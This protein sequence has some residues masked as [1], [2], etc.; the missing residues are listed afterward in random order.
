MQLQTYAKI[1]IIVGIAVLVI[2]VPIIALSIYLQVEHDFARLFVD[3][4]K[5]LQLMKAK[6]SYKN[7]L[8]RYPDPIIEERN[9]RGNV[10]LEVRTYSSI[11]GNELQLRL[12]YDYYDDRIYERAEC[13]VGDREYRQQL[14]HIPDVELTI[15]AIFFKE[16][17][18]REQYT[19]EFIK[20][21][22]C[23]E[24]GKNQETPETL[25]E[26][27][28][29]TSHYVAIPVDTSFPSCEESNACYRPYSLTISAGEVVEWQNF[30][31]AAH[32]V[33]SGTPD[34]GPDDYFD[35]AL[36]LSQE[37]FKVHMKQVGTFD[38]FCMVHPWM[39][40]KIIVEPIPEK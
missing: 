18:A 22:N 24:L 12:G 14:G 32:T 40:G 11:T 17:D 38:Y 26:E 21:T 16:G 27:I 23:L 39:T 10:E 6:E 29:Q 28:P 36:F 13:Q 4:N 25:S 8:D 2:F 15:P 33:T 34:D 19:A 7:F 37:S 1:G 30:D 9:T 31:D 5:Q 35:S 3:G 20:Y